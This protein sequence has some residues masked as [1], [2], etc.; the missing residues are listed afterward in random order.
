MSTRELAIVIWIMIGTLVLLIVK[1][2]RDSL[3]DVLKSLLELFKQPAFQIIILYQVL[4]IISLLLALR[5]L[6]LSLWGIKDY[7]IFFFATLFT[8]FGEYRLKK[9]WSSIWK[10]ISFGALLSF[11]ISNYTFPLWMELLGIPFILLIVL[12][13]V[14]SEKQNQL[15]AAGLFNGLIMVI[16]WT[17]I[18]W[19]IIQFSKN[20]HEVEKI[21]YWESFIVE[22]M[23]WVLNIPLIVFAIPLY[24]FDTLDNLRIAPKTIGRLMLDTLSFLIRVIQYSY[25]LLFNDLK[26]VSSVSQG[27]FF[28]RSF[29]IFL[30]PNVSQRQA[31]RIMH[32]FELLLVPG[33]LY[34]DQKKI[35]PIRIECLK[36]GDNSEVIPPYEISDIS[37][38]FK[39]ETWGL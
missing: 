37:E 33:S 15:A 6:E 11:M 3:L 35:I 20:W 14:I 22:F 8:L 4:V 5:H 30:F 34:R 38:E 39:F 27:G 13:A 23:A 29:K 7:W 28:R 2:L 16:A 17:T 26:Q 1:D 10:G 32:R 12:L 18:I 9:F 24:Q 36:K 25:I 19:T 31:R 21:S